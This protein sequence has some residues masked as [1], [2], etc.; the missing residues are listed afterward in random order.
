M[1]GI[2]VIASSSSSASFE[3]KQNKRVLH[4]LQLAAVG[5]C[6]VWWYRGAAA[7]PAGSVAGPLLSKLLIC[8]I[9][10]VN[11]I[12]SSSFGSNSTC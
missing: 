3:T 11:A 4:V 12:R 6:R 7:G 9:C 8:K 5:T 10:Y 2:D 1:A